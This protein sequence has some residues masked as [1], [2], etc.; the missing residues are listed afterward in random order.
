MKF[1]FIGTAACDYSP[2]LQTVYKDILDK[3]ARRSSAVLVDGHILV[4]CGHHTLDSL[5]IQ[6]ISCG[7][8]DILLLTHMHNDHY[9]PEN[10][11]AIACASQ[12]ELPI[13]QW[14][15]FYV[16]GNFSSFALAFTSSE[17][18][19]TLDNFVRFINEFSL[20]TS[21]IRIALKN[22][23]L[24]FVIL[25]V[26]YPFKVLVSYFLYKKIPGAQFYR[27]AFF[28]PMIIFSVC[29][30]LM[31]TRVIGVDGFIAQ[32]IG[33]WLGMEAAPSLLA[34]SRFANA[35]ILL[36]L[37]WLGFPGDLIIW[38]GT[39]SRI[40]DDVLEAGALDGVS[41]WSEFTKI[42]VPMVWPTVA[43]QM[44]LM[45]CHLFQA[46]GSVFL[47]TRGE[48]GTMTLSCWMYLKLVGDAGAR[49][50]STVYNYLSA[51][52]MITTVIAII[53][54]FVIRHFTDKMFDEVEF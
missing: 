52:G 46:S 47:L 12:R 19:F 33:E 7:D 1:R 48:Y 26:S 24:T 37:L 13:I 6:E 22:T 8:I 21:D 51:V 3:D 54:S 11:K 10:I 4:D 30:N 34:D 41:W 43:L 50:T 28:I 40:P 18:K 14:V 49:Y 27:L 16:Y 42:I 29:I 17:G 32:K 44:L 38:G 39:F 36:Q 31:F 45:F 53:I 35:V 23:L 2:L 5:R 25:F 9:I 15:I 20:P